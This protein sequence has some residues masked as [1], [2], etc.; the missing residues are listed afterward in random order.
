V[1]IVDNASTRLCTEGRAKGSTANISIMRG[2]LP[3]CATEGL[4]NTS[5]DMSMWLC[6]GNPSIASNVTLRSSSRLI[7]FLASWTRGYP[8]TISNRTTPADHTSDSKKHCKF[9]VISGAV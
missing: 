9:W 2:E 4:L 5:N 1:Y 3:T 8:K 6:L 7:A